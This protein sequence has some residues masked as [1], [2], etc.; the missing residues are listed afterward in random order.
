MILVIYYLKKC[1]NPKQFEN[2]YEDFDKRIISNYKIINKSKQYYKSMDKDNIKKMKNEY[3][4]NNN[5]NIK[6]FI[7][8]IN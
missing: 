5:M 4:K 6:I 3:I 1:L 7:P 2:I 8:I